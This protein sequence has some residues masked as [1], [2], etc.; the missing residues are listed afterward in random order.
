MYQVQKANFKNWY[1]NLKRNLKN[2]IGTT[3]KEHEMRTQ[4]GRIR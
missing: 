3:I 1:R 2:K 4:P